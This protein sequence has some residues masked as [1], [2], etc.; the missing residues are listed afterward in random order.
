MRGDTFCRAFGQLGPVKCGDLTVDLRGFCQHRYDVQIA[1]AEGLMRKGMKGIRPAGRDKQRLAHSSPR[2]NLMAQAGFGRQM[3]RKHWL[4]RVCVKVDLLDLML[5]R[6]CFGY[7]TARDKP[8]C[9]KDFPKRRIQI[10]LR[11]KR[12]NQIGLIDLPCVDQY[13]PQG[14]VAPAYTRGFGGFQL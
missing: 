6:Q 11:F 2:H 7:L 8:L 3:A 14:T 9:H 5:K 10:A 13:A 12:V 1:V 4:G